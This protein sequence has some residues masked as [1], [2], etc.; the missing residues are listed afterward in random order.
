MS[1]IVN[2][3][4]TSTVQGRSR[5]PLRAQCE[6][7]AY[8]RIGDYHSLTFV[9]PEIAERAKPG[10]FVSLG[11]GSGGVLRRPF[12]IY[13]VSQHGPWAGTVEIV[14]DVLG[15][16]TRWLAERTKHDTVDVVGPLGRPFPMPQQPVNCLLVGGGYGTAPLLYL[17]RQLTQRGLRVDM[18][19]GAKGQERIFNPIEAKRV[20]ASAQFTT[21][22]GSLGVEGLVTDVMPQ[23]MESAGTGVVYG[24]GP[25]PMLAA[26]SSVAREHGVPVQVAVEE[27]MACGTGVCFTCVV[28]MQRKGGLENVRACIDGPVLNGARV[29]WDLIG[30]REMGNPPEPEEPR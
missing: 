18:I 9:A 21:E 24:C 2:R 25:M 22:D 3:G 28:P 17:A 7:L 12:S 13:Q 23:V 15:K 29:A 4:A 10:Q 26:V 5:G 14:F 30:T 19:L 6:V 27:E 8:G 1:S 11:V 20:A 16:G